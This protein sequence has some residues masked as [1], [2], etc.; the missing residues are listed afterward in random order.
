MHKFTYTLL[1]AFYATIAFSQEHNKNYQEAFNLM[2]V[3]LAAQKDFEQLPGL[4]AIVIDDQQVLW[5]SAV[6]LSNPE[7]RIKSTDTTLYS[8]CSISKL[9]TSV[10]IM[11]LYDEGKLRL[12]DRIED[13]LP[14]YKLVQQYPESGPVT[15]RSL[16]THSSGLPRE[17]AY[18]Y[19]T[20]PDFPFPT[21]KQIDD[22]LGDQETLYPAS[23]YYQYSNLGLTLLGEVVEEISGQSFDEY[24]AQNILEPLGLSNTRPYM[25]EELYGD[26]L[27]LGYSAMT[28]SGQRENVNFFQ[29]NG[30]TPAAGFTSNVKDLGKFASWQFRLRDS[31]ITEILK[32]STLKNMHLVHWTDS[33]WKVTRGLGFWVQKGPNGGTWVGHGGSCP[34]Y[35]STL[36]L[37]L[38]NKRAYSVMINASGT[39][40]EKYAKGLDAIL[41]K[42][43]SISKDTG[44]VVKDLQEY[45]GFYSLLPWWGEVYVSSWN[46]KLV[47][48]GLPTNEPGD[49]M[50][51]FRHIEGDTFQRIRDD[52]ELGETLVFERDSNGRILHYTQHGNKAVKINK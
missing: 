36:Q 16:L 21:K 8:I 7:N 52:D 5:S 14:A 39:S 30:I 18:P 20:G 38:K 25:P 3:W 28:R 23:T 49:N 33:D 37:D 45:T 19:W 44:N 26:A 1:F 22:G 47:S 17:A 51:F 42:V 4:S 24:V 9:F 6:G 48:L 50:T 41:E 40:P 43:E 32:P 31:T 15:I 34:G 13:L 46:G 2:D 12:D 11:K 10:A 29:A 35:R 27:A